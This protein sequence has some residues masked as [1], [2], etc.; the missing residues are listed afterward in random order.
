LLIARRCF[1]QAASLSLSAAQTLAVTE[2]HLGNRRNVENRLKRLEHRQ[3][4]CNARCA[5]TEEIDPSALAV[6]RVLARY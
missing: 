3:Q 1:A 2:T 5:S 6:R 4:L